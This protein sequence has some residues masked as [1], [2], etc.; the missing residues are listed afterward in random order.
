MLAEV[1]QRSE[2]E[3]TRN[4][5]FTT[6]S[7]SALSNNE[8]VET[9]ENVILQ[10]EKGCMYLDPRGKYRYVD[11]DSSLRFDHAAHIARQPNRAEPT[12]PKHDASVLHPFITTVMPP[13][14]ETVGSFRAVE[15]LEVVYL[16]NRE[17]CLRFITKFFEQV[18]AIYWVYSPEQFYMLL[19][20]TL[21]TGGSEASA[22]WL[23]SL[24]S[25]F[26][27]CSMQPTGQEDQGGEKSSDDY[28]RMAREYGVRAADEADLGSVKALVLMSL[29]LNASFHSVMAYCTIGLTVRIAYSL[30]LHRNTAHKSLDSVEKERA[31]RLWW[32]LYQLDQEVSNQLGHPFAIVDE[33]ICIQTPFASEQI[34]DPGRNTPLGYQAICVSLIKLKKKISQSLYVTPAQTTRR[35]RFQQVTSCIASLYD[36]HASV[37]SHLRWGSSLAPSHL[38]AVSVLHLRYWITLVHVTRPF[39]LHSVTRSAEL[40]NS[41]KK[42]RYDDFSNLCIEAAENAI[43]ILKARHEDRNLSSLMLFDSGCIQ[44]LVQV[45]LLAE[46]KVGR[47]TYRTNLEFCLRAMRAMEAVG[48]CKR[49]LPDLETLLRD[50]VTL[51]TDE[52]ESR[53]SNPKA[54]ETQGLSIAAARTHHFQ[55]YG[56]SGSG[57]FGD[58]A[59]FDAAVN[60]FEDFEL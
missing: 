39:L 34:L 15:D 25:I 18:H 3:A 10:E 41:V 53:Q 51:N 40:R 16:P 12:R 8:L 5:V 7:N 19:D 13:S 44:E 31:R 47:G 30:G 6:K 56:L 49:I 27:I 50:T 14:P 52:D 57:L 29:A 45:F 59:A 60:S 43:V 38:R 2:P 33:A 17:T 28:L 22:S 58:A 46:E 48:W 1:E 36:W 35:V 32:T 20:Q 21:E 11:A 23:C 37:P 26:A 55:D 54:N 42:K 9:E 4:T 24:Y